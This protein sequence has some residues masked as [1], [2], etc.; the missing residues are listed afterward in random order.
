MITLVSA[1]SRA[2]VCGAVLSIEGDRAVFYRNGVRFGSTIVTDDMVSEHAVAF[3]LDDAHVAAMAK[4]YELH[5][6][7]KP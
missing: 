3:I 6:G 7:T 5:K 2:N 4:H 1:R